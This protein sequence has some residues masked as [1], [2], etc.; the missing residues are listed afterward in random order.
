M[1]G[2]ATMRK[3]EWHSQSAIQMHRFPSCLPIAPLLY[4]Q[5]KKSLTVDAR[6]LSPTFTP[7]RVRQ[8]PCRIEQLPRQMRVPARTSFQ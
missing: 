2:S 5:K 1:A 8:P 3:C 7:I 4:R 6:L